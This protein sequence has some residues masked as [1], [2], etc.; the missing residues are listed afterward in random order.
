MASRAQA[1]I[2]D[3]EIAMVSIQAYGL[4]VRVNRFVIAPIHYQ[5]MPQTIVCVGKIGPKLDGAAVS[6]HSL[7]DVCAPM[8]TAAKR[9]VDYCLIGTHGQSGPAVTRRL[10]RSWRPDAPLQDPRQ[11]D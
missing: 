4:P 1:V 2:G 7:D 5:C 8:Q 6:V 3:G 11:L 10:V 9:I